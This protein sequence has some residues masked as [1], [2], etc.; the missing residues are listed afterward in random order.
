MGN[1][2]GIN[3]IDVTS[4]F[5][6]MGGD[7]IIAIEIINFINKQQGTELSV[8]DLLKHS[9]IKLFSAYLDEYSLR[10]TNDVNVI[11]KAGDLEWYEASSAQKRIFILDQLNKN[12]T[13]YNIPFFLMIEGELDDKRL[14][15]A[16]KN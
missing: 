3:P 8:S 5:Y 4:D 13:S 15:D 10:K 2:L 6:E 14:E 1:A 11:P 12:S 9:N 7:S 16:F